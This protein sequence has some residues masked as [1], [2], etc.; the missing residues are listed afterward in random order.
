MTAIAPLPDLD[1]HYEEQ[2]SGPPVLLINDLGQSK[3]SWGPVLDELAEGYRV[4]SFDNRGVGETGAPDLPYTISGMAEDVAGLMEHLELHGAAVVGAGLGGIVATQLASE[5]EKLVERLVL[6]STAGR[7]DGYARQLITNFLDLRRSSISD[8]EFFEH[9][10]TLMY[11][12]EFFDD[13]KRFETVV[14]EWA[15]QPYADLDQ[16][17]IRQAQAVL[18]WSE[19]DPAPA[20]KQ[21]SL[22]LGGEED[23]IFSEELGREL[24]EELPNAA[25]E[26]LP[27][28][29][30]GIHEHPQ[31][32]LKAIEAFLAA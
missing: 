7:L 13:P 31:Q 18:E 4:V 27:G 16:G 3:E 12:R 5:H 6:A 28:G 29:H 21:K 17:F 20:P 14:D 10:T 15:N 19:L 32:W 9:L 11:S 22:V 25:Y 2:G 23:L 26:I 30:A 24:A 1:L 8:H